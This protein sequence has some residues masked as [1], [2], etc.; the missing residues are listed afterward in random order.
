MAPRHEI[1]ATGTRNLWN[2]PIKRDRMDRGPFLHP[3]TAL[4]R[5]WKTGSM[6]RTRRTAGLPHPHPFNK[7]DRSSGPNSCDAYT[8][9]ACNTNNPSV[10]ARAGAATLDYI[11]VLCLLLPLI[12]FIVPMGKRM[13]S[14]TYEMICVMVSWPFM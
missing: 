11:L 5:S 8:A 3:S 10:P 14:L 7:P 2:E 12:A 1:D 6:K 4:G 13:I 9:P